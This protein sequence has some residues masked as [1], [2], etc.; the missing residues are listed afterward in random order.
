[1]PKKFYYCNFCPLSGCPQYLL[2]KLQKVQNNATC[3]D[4]RVPN[5][6][7][8]SPHLACVHWLPPDSRIQYKL[9]SP[10]YNCL[11]SIAPVYLTELTVYKPS[12]QLCSSSDSSI[13]CLPSVRTH[14][15]G[16]K[17][18]FVCC[19]VCLEQSPLQSEI[20][21]HTLS[22]QSISETSAL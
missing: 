11:S 22:F 2:N 1:M 4:P 14:S 12:R 15:F 18:L 9:A 21:K 19:T 7:H 16:Q 20:I 13:L 5:N 3:L 10:C 6:Y 17:P 8:I